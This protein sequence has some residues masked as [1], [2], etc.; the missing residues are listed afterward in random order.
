[1]IK[2]AFDVFTCFL[3]LGLVSFGGPA[4]HLGY[5][6]QEFVHNKQWLSP[7]HYH[8]LLAL[9]QFLPGPGSSQVG[10]AIGLHRAG[11]LGALAA[12]I[13]FTLPSALL[14]TSLALVSQLSTE[15]TWM[16]GL[17]AGLKI[18]ALVVVIDALSQM[19]HQFC[20]NKYLITA[21]ILSCCTVL[22]IPSI[23]SQLGSL[24]VAALSGGFLHKRLEQQLNITQPCSNHGGKIRWLY[25][26]TF[27]LL[28]ILT[29][30]PIQASLATFS[31]FY[32]AGSWVFGGGHVVLPLLQ[33]SLAHQLPAEQ[34]L[35]AYAAAQAVPGPM[36]S[37]ASY[38]GAVVNPGSPLIGALLATIAI[39]LPGLLLVLVFVDVWQTIAQQ[40]K[41]AA[42]IHML[43][44]AVVGLLMAAMY[45]PI[46]ISAVTTNLDAVCAL[47]GLFLLRVLKLS[48]LWVLLS[49]A[50]TGLLFL[51]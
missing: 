4:A 23:A 36:F 50:L 35:S 47:L 49:L 7:Q 37:I 41:Y 32:Q 21:C 45:Q 5:F 29:W 20:R 22:L 18:A 2:S 44:A 26:A 14:M 39:F 28:M 30:L 31:H 19:Y 13:G 11:I 40:A 15:L 24:A 46:F 16:G 33:Q 8:N 34:L 42:A 12:F 27:I 3:R 38:L 9:S 48:V 17:I 10:F 1:M 51:G 43:N 6:Q 25:L